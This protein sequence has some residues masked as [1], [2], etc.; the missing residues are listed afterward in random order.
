MLTPEQMDDAGELTAAVY[1]QIEADLLAYLVSKMAEGD[2]S[3]QRAQTA[4]A[5]LSQSMPLKLK[6]I[7]ESHADELDAAAVRDVERALSASDAWDLAAIS[8]GLGVELASDALTA[9]TLAVTASVRE[10][11]ARDNVEMNAA[12]RSQYMKW[13]TWAANQV[14]T[15]NMTADRAKHSAVR[16]LAR[17]G[18]SI[19]WVQYRDPETGERTVRS[20]ADV[21]VQ[22]HIRT[23]IAQGAA[24]LTF[25]RCKESGCGFVEVSS[26]IGARPS[27]AEWHGRC[28]HL[29]GDVTVDGVTY[30]DF[31]EGTGYMGIRGPY[32]DLGDQLLGVNCR[33][34]F[35][36]WMPGMPRAYS[37]DPE[38][39]SGLSNDEVYEL[40]QKQRAIERDIRDDK[41]EVAAA[42]QAYDADPTPENQ[43]ELAKA[44]LK[45]RKRQE[46]MREFIKESNARCKPGTE[47][48]V[49]QPQREWAGDMPKGRLELPKPANRTLDQFMKMP[50]VEAARARAGLTRAELRER[51]RGEIGV[52]KGERDDFHLRSAEQQ[53]E[54][55]DA[56]LARKGR[57]VQGRKPVNEHLYNSLK[58]KAERQ[59][60]VVMRGGEDVHRHL[61][62]RGVLASTIGDVVLLREDATTSEVLE[63]FYHLEQHL[64]RDYAGLSA[65]E[66]TLRRE[67][68]AQ[69][70]LLNVAE[71]YNIP[72]AETDLT[73]RNLAKYERQ[74]EELTGEDHGSET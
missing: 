43:V 52:A 4:I 40:T 56:V 64:R 68:D 44:K 25:Q 47:V 31:Y 9:Q 67:I 33:H 15:G 22:R 61:D 66:M 3:G 72:K 60:A 36:P 20:R 50:S 8:E 16:K 18:L 51:I 74:L 55:L 2:V 19:E 28:Y 59:G 17:E 70:Y 1:R 11:I 49:R 48:L 37:P 42:Q 57:H 73:M 65:D 54:A 13:T 62:E 38:H 71:R 24:H 26:H 14:A 35:A 53:R 6:K 58:N 30:R 45:L 34:S 46:K 23:L 32:T 69:N 63:E 21:A 39:P 29:D 27:H 10:V 12:A 7:I 41:R 5:L